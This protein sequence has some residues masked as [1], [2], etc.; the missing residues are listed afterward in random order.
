MNRIFFALVIFMSKL[1]I[2]D[3]SHT[4]TVVN[5]KVSLKT[6]PQLL[7]NRSKLN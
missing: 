2:P 5:P 7:I 6:K 4:S 3:T 1:I